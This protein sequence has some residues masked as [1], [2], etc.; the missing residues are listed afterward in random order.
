MV[1]GLAGLAGLAGVEDLL[2]STNFLY[3]VPLAV[4]LKVTGAAGH[5]QRERKRA[6]S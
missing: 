1:V 3:V 6:M 2:G 4:G 5:T